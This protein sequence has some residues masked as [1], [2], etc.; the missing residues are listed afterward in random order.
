MSGD[1]VRRS[2]LQTALVAAGM[3]T[4]E[5]T[6]RSGFMSHQIKE[7]IQGHGKLSEYVYT[8]LMRHITEHQQGKRNV[9]E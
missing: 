4:R 7:A 1:E 6:R 9:T 8:S 5:L 2:K 3:S